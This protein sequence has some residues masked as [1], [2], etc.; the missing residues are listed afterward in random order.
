[1]EVKLIVDDTT[2]RFIEKVAYLEDTTVE[3][4]IR[5]AVSMR[6]ECDIDALI[7]DMLPGELHS[8]VKQ[9]LTT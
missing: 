4:W 5:K 1:M 7:S 8:G 6:V 3:E 2:H 9:L